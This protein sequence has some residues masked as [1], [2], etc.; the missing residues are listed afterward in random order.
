MKT[1]II[2][3]NDLDTL[4]ILS[5]VFRGSEY[6]VLTYPNSV[7]IE[8]ISTK[9]PDI[10]LL[11]YFLDDSLGSEMCIA[12]KENLMTRNVPVILMST[13]LNLK[14]ITFA[15]A[16]DGYIEKPFDLDLLT[17]SVKRLLNTCPN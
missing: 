2:I 1:I 11:D 9:N 6:Q 14:D 4:E 7:S 16:A 17:N 10:I 3:E 8:E 5:Y 13:A 15:C 12:L